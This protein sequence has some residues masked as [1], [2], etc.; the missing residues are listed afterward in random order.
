MLTSCFRFDGFYER[1]KQVPTAQEVF[2]IVLAQA[3]DGLE[4]ASE[5][6]LANH[7]RSRATSTAKLRARRAECRLLTFER[8]ASVVSM[9]SNN[10]SQGGTSTAQTAQSSA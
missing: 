4:A 2:E 1:C 9:R 8:S 5:R 10:R 6:S 7:P 3:G